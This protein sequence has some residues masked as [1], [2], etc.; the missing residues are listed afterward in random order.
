MKSPE[1]TV[2]CNRTLVGTIIKHNF[3]TTGSRN[4]KLMAFLVCMSSTIFSTRN[5]V[6]IEH[7][8][9]WE[10]HVNI[11]RDHSE[12]ALRIMEFVQLAK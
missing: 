6:R 11:L 12:V 1:R 7:T 2:E 8:I 3:E 4:Y 5:V 10:W 9:D